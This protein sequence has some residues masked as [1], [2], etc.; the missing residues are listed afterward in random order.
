M[1]SKKLKCMTSLMHTG[2]CFC[3]LETHL[4]L[5]GLLLT[6]K[7]GEKYLCNTVSLIVKMNQILEG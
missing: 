1:Q 6:L 3:T 5:L 7:I 2:G 4:H